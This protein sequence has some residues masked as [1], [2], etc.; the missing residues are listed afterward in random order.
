MHPV[1]RF[2]LKVF[3]FLALLASLLLFVVG[4]GVFENGVHDALGYVY[5]RVELR[6]VVLAVAFLLLLGS[7]RYLLYRAGEDEPPALLSRTE[8]GETR[9]SLA[10]MERLAERVVEAIPGIQETHVRFVPS[11]TEGNRYTIS[12]K[13]SGGEPLPD[14]VG[15][16]QSEVKHEVE[17]ATGVPIHQISVYVDNVTKASSARRRRGE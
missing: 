2:F 5:A 9:I 11:E 1:D 3:S 16:I 14:L 13:V 10:A 7:L 12:V 15:R 6:A 8:L 17:G 4:L